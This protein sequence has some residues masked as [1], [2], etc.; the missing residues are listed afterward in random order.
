[1]ICKTAIKVINS[2][3]HYNEVFM[4]QRFPIGVETF[5][6]I[7]KGGYAYADKTEVIYRLTQ[8]GQY[9]FLSRPRRFGKSLMLSTLHSYFDGRKDLF[10]GLW[11]GKADGVDWTPRPVFHLNF[12]STAISESGLIDTLEGHFREWEAKYGITVTDLGF[13]QRFKAV[14]VKAYEHTGQKV[15]ILVDEYDKVLVN[16]R[17]DE[18]LHEAVKAILKPIYSVLKSCDRY[19]EFAILSG[20]SRFSKL[21]LFSD[22]N[23]LRD[24]SFDPRYSTICGITAE[25]LT[26]Y[27]HEGIESFAAVKAMSYD[28]VL[29]LLKANYDGYHFS[30]SSPD[31][32]NPYSLINALDES[33]INHRWFESGTPT[34]LT[35]WIKSTDEDIK[36]VLSPMIDSVTM[37]NLLGYEGNLTSM[38]YQTGYLT[39]KSYDEELDAY[40]LGIPNREVEN[41]LY[42]YLLPLYSGTDMAVNSTKLLQLRKSLIE[43]DPERFMQ[44]LK[45]FIGAIPYQLTENKHEIYFENNLNLIFKLLGLKSQPE[46]MTSDGRIDIAL[47]TSKYIYIFE[48]KLN[49]TAEEA[50]QQIIEKQYSLP[51]EFE[52]KQI[53]RIGV[54]FSGRTRTID[55]WVI[56]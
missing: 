9:F 35:E 50:L 30:K 21:S 2:Q 19:I 56:G 24:I 11:L 16:T 52:G 48:L 4:S 31:I 46:F 26:R 28:D 39:I 40:Q 27:F 23:N 5:E 36:E 1:M 42:R 12:V 49:G 7:I 15:A 54:N 8:G 6:K 13:E 29:R 45:S 18:A 37:Y 55:K 17:H 25:E 38:L 44:M 47:E 32:F 22:I 53:I 10:E 34:F 51:F 33:D 14:I 20:V 3:I 41:G 43:G